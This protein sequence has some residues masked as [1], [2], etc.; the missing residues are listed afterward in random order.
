MSI[1]K[2]GMMAYVAN[3]MGRASDYSFLPPETFARMVEALVDID[4]A[5]MESSGA[6]EEGVYD[7]EAAYD[8]LFVGLKERFPSITPT[9]C[10]WWR[11]TWTPWRRT[12]KARIPW[13]GTENRR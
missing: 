3:A 1:E 5:Y 11:T 2:S 6:G 10:A 4:L 12:W 7:D 9:A 13:N 8:L